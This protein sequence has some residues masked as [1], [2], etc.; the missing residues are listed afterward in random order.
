[1]KYI[2]HKIKGPTTEKSACTYLIAF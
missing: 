1:L 2:H